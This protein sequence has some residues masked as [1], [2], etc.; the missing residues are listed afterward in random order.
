[1]SVKFTDITVFCIIPPIHVKTRIL[2]NYKSPLPVALT[3]PSN[4]LFT[5]GSHPARISLV[6]T[7]SA[8]SK[9]PRNS[10]SLTVQ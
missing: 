5:G 4:F 6:V 8:H 10:L 1:M 3:P 9:S 2:F 7:L